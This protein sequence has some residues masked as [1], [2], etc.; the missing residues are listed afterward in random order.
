MSSP[1][2]APPP[3]PPA[4]SAPPRPPVPA[5]LRRVRA[6]APTGR[7]T[8]GSL[9]ASLVAH[10]VVLGGLWLTHPLVRP[11]DVPPPP[12]PEANSDGE[13]VSFFELSVYPTPRLPPFP[14][15]APAGD[16]LATGGGARADTATAATPLPPFP[17]AVPRRLPAAAGGGGGV[18]TLAP[19]GAPGAAQPGGGAPGGATGPG[20]L[21]SR[22][23]GDRRLWVR[24]EAVQEREPSREEAYRRHFLSRL[25]QIRDSTI[26]D[27]EHQ[28]RIRNWTFKDGQGREWGIAEGGAPVVAGR[29]IPL[30]PIQLGQRDRDQEDAARGEAGQRA[31]IDRQA[32]DVSRERHLKERQRVVR[33]R[34]DSI[35]AARR[36]REEREREAAGTT[37]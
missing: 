9:A 30:P 17:T 8:R 14:G 32:E 26:D 28:R 1:S 34:N 18:P 25:E 2:L 19:G 22:G 7:P 31:E 6:G 23:F 29:R 10:V 11:V 21:G 33:E 27:M 35:R 24:P 3:A 5:P 4:P 16:P 12:P 20:G 15:A 13:Q 36:A 37:P